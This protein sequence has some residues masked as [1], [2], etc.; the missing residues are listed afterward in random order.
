MKI[1]SLLPI[2]V[3]L[4]TPVKWVAQEITTLEVWEDVSKAS[5]IGK[6]VS[7]FEAMYNCQ[8]KIR[9]IDAINQLGAL[10]EHI[11]DKSSIPDVMILVSDKMGE[12]VKDG[13]LSPLDFMD[14]DRDQYMDS[15]V[16]AFADGGKFY[17][18]PRSVESLVVYYNQDMIEYPLE[19]L[20]EYEKNAKENK[21]QGKLGL[22]GKFDDIYYAYGF[23]RG[24]GGYIFG[25]NP[26]G[27]LNV[28]DI[29]IDSE[30]AMKG[31]EELTDYIKSSIPQD[32]FEKNGDALID[33]LFMK[34]KA[35][36]VINGPWALEKYAKAGVNIGI[37]PLPKLKNGQRLAPFYGVKGYAVPEK[38]QNKILAAKLIEFLNQPE[39]A[40]DRYFKKA[41]LPPIKKLMDESFIEYD[42]LANAMINEINMLDPM[43]SVDKMN[44]VWEHLNYALNRSIVYG[45][46]YKSTFK[47]AKIRIEKMNSENE[48]ASLNF[49]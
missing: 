32:I 31:L 24:Y 12:A 29:G 19:T 34:G 41:E 16:G 17:T 21:K 15:A 44:E 43:P 7:D 28:H 2:I 46:P 14:T 47:N 40:E 38:A 42:E 30:K 23:I 6:A 45:I 13:L 11:K 26:D 39:Y 5:A 49:Q 8:V 20:S 27:S 3:A 1:L 48:L 4:V 36:A 35:S 37:A 22:I 9:E 25:K 10:M 18:A 33:T